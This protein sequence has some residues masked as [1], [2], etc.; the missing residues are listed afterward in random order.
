ASRLVGG[1]ELTAEDAAF[2]IKRNF[3]DL[4]GSDSR[5]RNLPVEWPVSVTA[6]DKYTVVVKTNPGYVQNA[7]LYTGD[8]TKI[9]PPELVKKY[10]DLKD[11]K[12]NVGSGPFI[13]KDYVPAS[14]VTFVRNPNY[15]QHDPFF[16][17][18]QLPY[19]DG[20]KY[21]YITD[22][23]TIMAGLRTGK[24]DGLHSQ[25]LK[26]ISEDVKTLTQAMPEMRF[27]KV[28]S[29]RPSAINFVFRNTSQ[30]WQD[31]RV[32]H[33]LAM[34]IDRQAIVRDYYGGDAEIH[35]A[36][37]MPVDEF[38][39]MYTPLKELPES[40]RELY[41]YNPDKA[42][43][44]L[45]EAGYPNGFKINVDTSVTEDVDL[46]SLVKFYWQK[47]G[48]EMVIN[49]R[50]AS[51][52]TSMTGGNAVKEAG[53]TTRATQ[54]PFKFDPFMDPGS[55]NYAGVNDSGL[56]KVR[57]FVMANYVLNEDKTWK[58]LK[59]A[60]VEIVNQT[61]YIAMPSP[62]NFRPYQPWLK[63]YSG[64]GVTGYSDFQGESK[65]LWIDQALKKKLGF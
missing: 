65:Y 39:P 2:S 26:F 60:F 6:T 41:T 20:V 24:I 27:R 14:A 5:I 23:S 21:L 38:M 49:P 1:R 12:N 4:P 46:L 34:A 30:P 17:E 48:V 57:P 64:E 19:I 15:W 36:P 16:L 28:L 32:R 61:Y 11:W 50:E 33:A 7:L 55:G 52:M 59:E 58:S 29:E 45:A 18:N 3:E 35:A 43:K 37:V 54:L 25:L 13:I 42:K 40:V 47:V 44:L 22:K 10:G 8:V 53:W 9:Y 56:A 51:V 63:G 62:Y 31:I